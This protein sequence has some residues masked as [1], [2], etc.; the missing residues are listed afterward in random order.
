MFMWNNI[1]FS[2]A[3]D[4]KDIYQAFGGDDA[5]HTAAVSLRMKI[6]VLL[7]YCVPSLPP[8]LSVLTFMA[9][10]PT[11][12]LR[13]KVFTLWPPLSWTTE[14]TGSFASRSFKVKVGGKDGVRE[15]ER[16]REEGSGG[17]WEGVGGGR[18]EGG[19]G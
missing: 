1:F 16:E 2:L 17:G 13:R 3:F 11:R 7:S 8:S 15:R 9:C 12:E 19:K 10:Q 14:V 6:R 4:G 5:A 18:E